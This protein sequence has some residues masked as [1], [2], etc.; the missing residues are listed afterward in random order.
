MNDQKLSLS[1]KV[2]SL[3][4]PTENPR[5]QALEPGN[6]F[7]WSSTVKQLGRWGSPR[8]V[9]SHFCKENPDNPEQPSNIHRQ[10]TKG[11]QCREYYICE[12]R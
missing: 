11:N 1:E 3:F 8:H 12:Q 6:F 4:G 7:L 10:I 9:S 2:W 5:M